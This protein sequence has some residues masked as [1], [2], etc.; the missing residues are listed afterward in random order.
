MNKPVVVTSTGSIGVVGLLWVLLLFTKMMGLSPMSWLFTICF[1]LIW[2]VCLI[3]FITACGCLA[4]GIA[5]LA[6]RG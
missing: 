4:A 2:V 3:A 5:W 6:K 1:P